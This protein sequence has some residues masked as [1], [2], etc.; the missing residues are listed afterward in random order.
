MN[1]ESALKSSAMEPPPSLY[2]QQ[3][4]HKEPIRKRIQYFLVV[5]I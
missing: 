2:L 5:N 4:L 1:G 3:E